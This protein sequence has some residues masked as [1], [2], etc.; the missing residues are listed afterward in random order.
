MPS[1]QASWARF[2]DLREGVALRFPEV[3][4]VLAADEPADVVAVLAEVDQA[5][6]AGW[7][8]FGFVAYEAAP[9]LDPALAAAEPVDGLPLAWFGLCKRPEPVPVVAPV[10]GERRY[11]AG[12]WKCA[13]DGPRHARAV[14]TVRSCIAAGETYQCNL[15]TRMSGPVRGELTELYADLALSQRGAYNA[16]LDLG[17]FAVVSASPELFFELRDDTLVMRPMKGTA[18]RGRARAEDDVLAEGLRASAKDRA[19]NVMIVDLVRNDAG[20][21]AEAGSV[22][23]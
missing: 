22:A 2:D 10:V 9:A 15:T 11:D 1:S 23:V 21:V 12:P 3:S 8:A 20:R 7:W 13:W 17:R 18:R 16:F 4:R 5:T 6:A 14:E 19:E